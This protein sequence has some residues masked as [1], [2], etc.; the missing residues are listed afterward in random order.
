MS[1]NQIACGLTASAK[2]IYLP[3]ESDKEGSVKLIQNDSN[4]VHTVTL[5]SKEV[6]HLALVP[7]VSLEI[8]EYSNEL[9]GVTGCSI[10]VSVVTKNAMLTGSRH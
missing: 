2:T 10:S 9:H 8:L 4:Y 1:V 3:L 7:L 5:G 6:Q